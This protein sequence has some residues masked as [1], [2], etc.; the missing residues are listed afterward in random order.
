[1]NAAAKSEENKR[2]SARHQCAVPIE[3]KKGTAFANS[4]TV[5][6]SKDGAG[7][8]VRD[9]VAINTKM[10]VELNLHPDEE[11]VIAVGQV[12]WIQQL[13]DSD[14]YRVGISFTEVKANA[15]SRI[16]KYFK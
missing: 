12:K 10:A 8:I 2:K 3:G 4:Q 7:L 1:M 5:D 15:K 16:G 11:P 14:A 13:P 9:Y 6:I